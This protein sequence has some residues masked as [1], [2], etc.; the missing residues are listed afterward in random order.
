M[1]AY[2]YL[3]DL[4]KMWLRK[5]KFMEN[6]ETLVHPFLQ[7]PQKINSWIEPNQLRAFIWLHPYCMS[8][9]AQ[10]LERLWFSDLSTGLG[11]QCI[12][13]DLTG[14]FLWK[15]CYVC[16]WMQPITVHNSLIANAMGSLSW[17]ITQHRFAF[18]KKMVW[19]CFINTV[20]FVT[21]CNCLSSLTSRE[22]GATS[23]AIPGGLQAMKTL[24][25]SDSSAFI[26]L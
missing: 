24:T 23:T 11:H 10:G 7:I 13:W 15:M 26:F 22:L 17:L 18:P 8:S 5:T 25:S 21:S 6:L 3:P 20:A 16:R 1:G 2:H 19:L 12:Q 9:F 14:N 4:F